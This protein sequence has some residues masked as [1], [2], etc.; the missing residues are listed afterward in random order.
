V[1]AGRGRIFEFLIMQ[2]TAETPEDRNWHSATVA[3]VLDGDVEAYAE[4]VTRHRDRLLRYA[5]RMLCDA[6]EADDVTQETFVRAYRSLATC[7]DP[8]RFGGWIFSILANRCRTAGARRAKR[9][10]VFVS[11]DAGPGTCAEPSAQDL[12]AA[13]SE[14]STERVDRALMALNAVHREAFLL[15]YVEDM[16][17]D[18]IA[19]LTGT[20]VSALKMR[21]SR[22]RS[23]LRAALTEVFDD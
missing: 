23:F 14:F 6:D 18:E 4:L 1:V 17:Y 13:G 11:S 9:E 19:V 15:K 2:I 22:A 20:G 10:A 16:S 7:A 3:R 8:S 21:V 12:D 5:V